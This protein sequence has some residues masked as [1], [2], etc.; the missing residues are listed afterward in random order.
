MPTRVSWRL[1]MSMA[2]D[3]ERLRT[4]RWA[5]VMFW[6]TVRWGNRLNCW[7][8]IPTSARTWSMS[9]EA[10]VNSNPLT[11]TVPV[12]GTSNRLMQRSTVDLPE[13]L[14]PTMTSTS[15]SAT[16]RSMSRTA[17]MVLSKV[18]ERPRRRIIGS[19]W[20]STV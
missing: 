16:S 9:V 19:D 7:N 14:G 5:R 17:W 11:V 12:V 8:T 18:L 3:L 15:P 13:P 10:S 20:V 2:S 1:A 6:I 4:L